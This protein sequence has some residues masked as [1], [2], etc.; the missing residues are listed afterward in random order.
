MAKSQASAVL[1][2]QYDQLDPKLQRVHTLNVKIKGKWQP[3][4]NI[5][6]VETLKAHLLVPF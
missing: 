2:Q 3:A 4:Q 1:V 5:I 6:L